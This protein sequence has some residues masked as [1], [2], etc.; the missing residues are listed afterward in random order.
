[1]DHFEFQMDEKN[2]ALSICTDMLSPRAFYSLTLY[3]FFDGILATRL[4]ENVRIADDVYENRR[5]LAQCLGK[6]VLEVGGIGYPVA[7]GTKGACVLVEGGIAD[8]VA[9]ITTPI[10]MPLVGSF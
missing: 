4:R 2:P 9:D 5:L 1:M 10:E 3:A 7:H 8:S 6:G